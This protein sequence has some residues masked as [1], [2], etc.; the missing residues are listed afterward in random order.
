MEKTIMVIHRAL[1]DSTFEPEDIEQLS[2]AYED[3]LRALELPDRD[4][5][6]TQIIAQR[7]IE[8]AKTGVRD[9]VKL[10]N[11]AVKDLRVP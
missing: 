4:D 3:A 2:T 8:A 10:C 1:Q 11:L 5:P 6:I 7:I 9:P